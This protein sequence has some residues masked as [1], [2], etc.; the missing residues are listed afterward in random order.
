MRGLP[1]WM[2]VAGL[3]GTLAIG[4]PML[5]V[6]PPAPG[7]SGDSGDS[8]SDTAD[9]ADSG[10]DS[11]DSGVDSADSGVDTSD[12]ADSGE[13]PV[14]DTSDSA[15]TSD[16]ASDTAEL[17]LTPA[18]V[19]VEEKGGFSCSS[20]GVGAMGAAWLVGLTVL[21]TRRRDD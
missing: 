19:T 1:E 21:S 14:V 4:L 15:D 20:A 2:M 13:G 9:S 10:L 12:S 11:A 6:P 7:D 16:T 3:V 8:G 5:V 18:W 17:P